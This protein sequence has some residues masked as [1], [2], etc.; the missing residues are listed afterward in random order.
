LDKL[1]YESYLK[2]YPFHRDIGIDL[3]EYGKGLKNGLKSKI[4][5]DR[6]SSVDPTNTEVYQAELD[7][8]IRLHFLVTQRKVTTILEFGV[9]KST[10][11]FDNALSINIQANK[12]FTSNHLRRANA[13]ECHS[14]D[15]SKLYI[16]H[17]KNNYKL[18]NSYL[19]FSKCRMGT[20][21]DRICTYYDSIPNICPDFIYLDGPSQYSVLGNVRGISTNNID[22][23]P[24][25]GDILLIEYFLLPGTLIVVDGRTAN[26]RFLKNNLQRNWKYKYISEFDQHFFEL[27][28]APL[29]LIN[30][31][32]IDFS[33]LYKL[34]SK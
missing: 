15:D 10:V 2:K 6:Y 18:K 19:H 13:F 16:K 34:R 24:M 20:F 21:N 14:V 32:Q 12:E 30:K 4:K 7:D 26:A 5:T 28:E 9:G 1:T 3:K 11:V 17:V 25:A 8:L 31:K 23:L 27:T 22:R 29:G 33:S